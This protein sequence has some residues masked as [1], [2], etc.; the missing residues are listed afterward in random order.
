MELERRSFTCEELEVRSEGDSRTISGH[1]AKF[2]VLS[3]NLGFFREQI[4]P[5]AFGSSI[6][7]DIRALWSHDFSQVLGRTKN[8]TLRLQ[9]D[10]IG[11]RFELD[12]PDTTLGRDAYTSIKRGDVTAMS[13]GFFVKRDSWVHGGEGQPDIRTLEDIELFEISPVAFPA[14]PQTEV[15]TRALQDIAKRGKEALET[16]KISKGRSVLLARK[17]L[18]L[19]SA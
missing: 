8:G 17:Q 18:D 16:S 14:Y 12:L 7:G 3:E 13:F 15:H 11:L 4:K 2:N 9:E 6:G 10:E 19:L 5:G 1:A